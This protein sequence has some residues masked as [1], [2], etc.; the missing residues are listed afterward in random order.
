MMAPS[1][2]RPPLPGHRTAIVVAVIGVV[3]TLGA[4]LIGNWDRIFPPKPPVS[5]DSPPLQEPERIPAEKIVLELL[6]ASNEGDRRAALSVADQS[7][8]D[9]LFGA[10]S[11]QVN[12]RELTCYPAG[13]G[14]RDC[15][16]PHTKG[17]LVF[18]LRET[19]QG[20]WV[21]SVDY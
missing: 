4:A 5:V 18:R 17:L 11:L 12:S 20:W 2:Q 16:I 8:V 9:V 3:G 10:S 15:Q 1:K 7:V 6:R 13:T 14:Q 19:D 21:E